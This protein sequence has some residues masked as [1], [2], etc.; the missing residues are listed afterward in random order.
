MNDQELDN[1]YAKKCLNSDFKIKE[2]SSKNFKNSQR[3]DI[4]YL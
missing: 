3:R 4:N 1:L 2:K